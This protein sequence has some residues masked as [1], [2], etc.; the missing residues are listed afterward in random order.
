M[1]LDRIES[2]VDKQ[3][4]L[5]VT[6]LQ[7]ITRK[8]KAVVEFLIKQGADVNF[9]NEKLNAPLMEAIATAYCPMIDYLLRQGAD[10]N[11]KDKF[12]YTPIDVARLGKNPFIINLIKSV[13]KPA[14]CHSNFN[15]FDNLTELLNGSKL[16]INI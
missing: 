2:A 13:G 4:N 11:V 5:Q 14:Q 8:Q 6:L 16:S 12:G 1:I 9:K 10:V 3:T 15:A 7:C